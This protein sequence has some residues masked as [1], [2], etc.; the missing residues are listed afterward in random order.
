MF[1]RRN[2]NGFEWL[3]FS[4]TVEVLNIDHCDCK[5][6][7][8]HLL[9]RPT[10]FLCVGFLQKESWTTEG[11]RDPTHHLTRD[12][13][14]WKSLWKPK[15]SYDEPLWMGRGFSMHPLRGQTTRVETYECNL[16]FYVLQTP[17]SGDLS[18]DA[19]PCCLGW[20]ASAA[21]TAS[22]IAP[23]TNRSVPLLSHF[24]YLYEK[25]NHYTEF[26]LIKTVKIMYNMLRFYDGN[27]NPLCLMTNTNKTVSCKF[28]PSLFWCKMKKI[29]KNT[30]ANTEIYK[31]QDSQV[32]TG[33]KHDVPLNLRYT[34]E[35]KSG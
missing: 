14:E 6:Q 7:S 26:F 4:V 13:Y 25:K 27:K 3:I 32:K 10:G 18:M 2:K 20:T 19:V 21:T 11:G 16:A 30:I 12:T 1:H 15:L 29:V 24:F 34:C 9:S 22:Y 23:K 5:P 8:H 33:S 28:C 17:L 35:N 31:P